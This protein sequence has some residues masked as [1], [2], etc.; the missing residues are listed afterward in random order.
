MPLSAE[1][2]RARRRPVLDPEPTITVEAG[3]SEGT[4]LYRHEIQYRCD[5]DF[6]LNWSEGM[7][8]LEHIK[9]GGKVPD[10]QGYGKV[11]RFGR[12]TMFAPDWAKMYRGHEVI[13]TWQK[14][15]TLMPARSIQ[16][17]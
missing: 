4:K 14:G 1:L 3:S 8:E 2:R 10:W 13:W 7:K 17:T 5:I 12:D 16:T 6:F 9:R 15:Q 11:G